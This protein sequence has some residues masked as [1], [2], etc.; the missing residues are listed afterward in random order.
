LSHSLYSARMP[1]CQILTADQIV[2][3]R[4]GGKILRDCLA[5]IAS[6]VKPGVTTG[7]LD[8][9]AERFIRAHGGRPAFK[10]YNGFTGTLC[11]SVNDEVVHGIP[12]PREIQAGDIVSLD[13][14]VIYDGL[15]T[16]ACITVGAGEID[17]A[18]KKFLDVTSDTLEKVVRKVVKAG[19]HVGDISSFIQRNLE[20]AGYHPIPTLTGHGL[21]STLH[22]FPDVPNVGKAGSGP[23]LPAGT[24]IAI[25]PIPTMGS[26]EVY[27]EDDGWTIRTVDGNLSCHFEHTVL[28]TEGGCEIIA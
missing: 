18:T 17:P 12:G 11:I 15:Y 8:K 7:E 21:G 5:H 19:V 1:S 27:T 20:G 4:A 26:T 3:I 9:E 10:G 22:Q 25:E 24:V 14:G 28:I 13:G 6:L 16:D 23:Q 2:S